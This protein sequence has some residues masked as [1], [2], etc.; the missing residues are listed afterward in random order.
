MGLQA[1]WCQLTDSE[2]KKGSGLQPINE[3]L[4]K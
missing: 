2:V 1:P 3:L 4:Q